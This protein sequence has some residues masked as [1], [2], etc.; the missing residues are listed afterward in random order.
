MDLELQGK[1]AIVTGGATGIGYAIAAELT[2]EGVRVAIAGRRPEMLR[3]AALQI[4]TET[5]REAI[6][7]VADTG[8]D[9]TVRAL[10]DTVVSEL[11]GVDILVNVASENPAQPGGL[12]YV[13][14]TD[15]A[16]TR[17]LNVKVVGYLR[18]ARAVAPHMVEQGW[19]RIINVAGIGARQ[20][21]S[22]VN[23][24]RNVGVVALTKNLADELGPHGVTATAIYPGYTMTEQYRARLE[25]EALAAGTS[26]DAYVAGIDTG[27]AIGRFVRPEEV[28]WVVAF[29]ASPKS[30]TVSGDAIPVGGG[31]LGSIHY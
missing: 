9:E 26:F 14:A 23:S 13:H 30:V 2:R 12:S 25:Q 31:F 8:D 17:Q 11:G 20:T 1:R 19:G 7:V 5:G 21:Y 27:N 3:A 29:L 22:V 6:P 28:A 4:G 15:E 16:F 18:T 10:V 24:V